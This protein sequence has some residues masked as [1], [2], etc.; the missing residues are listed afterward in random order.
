M[1]VSI[2]DGALMFWHPILQKPL[3][4]GIK[5]LS[6]NEK[7]EFV[8]ELEKLIELKPEGHEKV[9]FWMQSFPAFE[10]FFRYLYGDLTTVAWKNYLNRLKP[11]PSAPKIDS[12]KDKVAYEKRIKDLENELSEAREQIASLVQTVARLSAPAAPRL[13]VKKRKAQ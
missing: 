2:K 7:E 3:R 8:Q 11:L 9:D 10:A 5:K 13:V 12:E 6:S 1:S 4:R